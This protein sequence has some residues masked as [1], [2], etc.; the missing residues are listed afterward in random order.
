M[1][2]VPIECV[3]PNSIIGKTLY[4]IDGRILV[5]SG[6]TLTEGIIYKIK[7]VNI[8]SIYIIDEYSSEEI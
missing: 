7:N 3:K 4:D 5:R 2:L 6:L 1:R 8:L